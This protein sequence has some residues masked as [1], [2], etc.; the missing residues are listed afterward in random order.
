MLEE[1]P[2]EKLRL[3]E[4]TPRPAPRCHLSGPPE[5]PLGSSPL[6]VVAMPVG[7]TGGER[8]QARASRA[9]PIQVTGRARAAASTSEILFFV[10][11]VTGPNLS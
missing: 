8:P 7:P 11:L 3:D 2:F 6:Q 4:K 10:F 1:T 5:E 9:A